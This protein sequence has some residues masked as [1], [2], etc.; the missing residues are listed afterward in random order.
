MEH[1]P[2]PSLLSD[3]SNHQCTRV[4]SL[5]NPP[6][7]LALFLAPFQGLTMKPFASLQVA[8]ILR[9]PQ[10][11]MFCLLF[12]GGF[13]EENS[14]R[15]GRRTAYM[16]RRTCCVS[17]L[18]AHPV[19]PTVFHLFGDIGFGLCFLP[20]LLCMGIFSESIW[21]NEAVCCC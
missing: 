15:R 4:I 6:R 16:R 17:K 9:P 3:T 19:T 18:V 7:A 14:C 8:T 12:E 21:P 11:E 10:L 13:Q 2:S 1:Q 5:R 20:L